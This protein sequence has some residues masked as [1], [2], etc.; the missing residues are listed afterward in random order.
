MWWLV[1]LLKCCL[2]SC[3][4][5]F[6]NC[7]TQNLAKTICCRKKHG[8]N[9]SIQLSPFKRAPFKGK[10]HKPCKSKAMCMHLKWNQCIH[11]CLSV[12]AGCIFSQL[13]SVGCSGEIAAAAE[14][15]AVSAMMNAWLLLN[16]LTTLSRHTPASQLYQEDLIQDE[17]AYHDCDVFR[18]NIF[19][20]A[21]TKYKTGL[22][23]LQKGWE[24]VEAD[25][26][27]STQAA[28]QADHLLKQWQSKF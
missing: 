2:Q 16:W 17:T 3:V 4:H 6:A 5:C 7:Q 25:Q 13:L 12:W 23:F 20:A 14:V 18:W 19:M 9:P 28:N 22:Y 24:Y 26:L 1:M 10:W 15:K 8:K 11:V 21:N 27:N